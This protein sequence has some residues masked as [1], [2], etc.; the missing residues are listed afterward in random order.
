M[1]GVL[2]YFTSYFLELMTG[3]RWWDYSGYLLNL[4]GRICAERLLVFGVG[5]LATVYVLAPLLDNG[6]QRVPEKKLALICVLLV[7]AFAADALHSQKYPNAGEGIDAKTDSPLPPGQIPG[8]QRTAVKAFPFCQSTH[9]RIRYS[10]P[11]ERQ[12]SR[13]RSSSSGVRV[14][15]TVVNTTLGTYWVQSLANRSMAS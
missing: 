7:M 2:E 1:C 9:G 12:I 4:H 6:I 15:S 10:A 11:T 3:M 13:H 5:G 14:V 8:Q